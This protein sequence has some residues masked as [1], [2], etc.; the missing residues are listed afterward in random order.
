MWRSF[1]YLFFL[2]GSRLSNKLLCWVQ[3]WSILWCLSCLKLMYCPQD[4]DIVRIPTKA[5]ATNTSGNWSS[6]Q[7]QTLYLTKC[8]CW[9][10]VQDLLE[11]YR[12]MPKSV[13]KPRI[14]ETD[15]H[16]WWSTQSAKLIKCR[17]LTEHCLFLYFEF[18]DW[19]KQWDHQ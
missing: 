1:L 16:H 11:W 14:L 6:P 15:S 13:L 19:S 5:S 12:L 9:W 18:W 7:I 10:K 3:L 4:T 8:T 2:L 17:L